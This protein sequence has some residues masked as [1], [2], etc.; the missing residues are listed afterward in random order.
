MN[1]SPKWFSEIRMKLLSA[2]VLV[3]LEKLPL[4]DVDFASA[5]HMAQNALTVIQQGC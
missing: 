2:E 1:G 3:G 5:I 4:P